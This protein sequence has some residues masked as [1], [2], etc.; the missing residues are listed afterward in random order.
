MNGGAVDGGRRFQEGVEL[1]APGND[2]GGSDRLLA[3]IQSPV[4]EVTVNFSDIEDDYD[5][6]NH[7]PGSGNIDIDPQFVGVSAGNLRLKSE[8]PCIDASNNNV[9]PAD[10]ADLDTDGRPGGELSGLAGDFDGD[11]VVDIGKGSQITM[12]GGSL[13]G[14]M[15]MVMGS[16]EPEL[17]AI[18]PMAGGGGVT[19][20]GMRT[21]QGTCA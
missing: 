18:A 2:D 3:Q 21:T 7:Y 20:L 4:G 12:V 9:V 8:S 16:V 14:M 15:S 17:D 5:D 13:G 11:G 1:R 19:D 6:E 10:V